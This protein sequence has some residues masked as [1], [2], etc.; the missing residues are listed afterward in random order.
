MPRVASEKVGQ[1]ACE[2]LQHFSRHGRGRFFRSP[3]TRSYS[4][5]PTVMPVSGSTTISKNAIFVPI[6]LGVALLSTAL[7]SASPSSVTTTPPSRYINVFC[8]RAGWMANRSP[9]EGLISRA[10]NRQRMRS[11]SDSLIK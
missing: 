2:A 5:W 1:V 7:V 11:Q 8:R 3:V 9:F 4:T 6:I 10:S